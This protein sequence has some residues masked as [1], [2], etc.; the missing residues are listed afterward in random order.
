[1]SYR[2]K[3]RFGV[4]CFESACPLYKDECLIVKALLK[5]IGEK[6]EEKSKELEEKINEMEKDMNLARLGF[7]IMG[8]KND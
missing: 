1:M 3:T 6:E 7:S 8:L 4:Y 5:Y 2:D